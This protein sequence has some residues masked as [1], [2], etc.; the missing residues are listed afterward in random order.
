MAALVPVSSTV[1]PIVLLYFEI[2][3][4][5]SFPLKL[6]MYPET[7]ESFGHPEN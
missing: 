5:D 2:K 3:G 4:S 7:E 1:R 6:P